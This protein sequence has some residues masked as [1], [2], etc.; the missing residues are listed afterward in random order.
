[1]EKEITEQTEVVKEDKATKNIKD[2]TL[3]TE[4]HFEL[5]KQYAWL[6]SAMIGA[7]VILIQLKFVVADSSI[8]IPL[9]LL[10]FSIINSLFAQDYI[11]ESLSKGKDI[12]QIIKPLYF[13]RMA[14]IFS[15]GLAAGMLCA[16]FIFKSAA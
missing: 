1:M 9:G 13:M 2:K 11:V 7:V 12:Q 15:L 4:L 10:G 16:L 5:L 14:S 6:S 8:F 3:T